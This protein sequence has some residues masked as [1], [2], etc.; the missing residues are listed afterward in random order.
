MADHVSRSGR[1]KILQM[2]LLHYCKVPPSGGLGRRP[3][4]CPTSRISL[5]GTPQLH[6]RECFLFPLLSGVASGL[7]LPVAPCELLV[8]STAYMH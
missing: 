4:R 7:C 8:F 6:R 5:V 1:T 2:N 3:H